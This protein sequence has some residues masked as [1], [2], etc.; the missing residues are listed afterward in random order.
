ML[1]EGIARKYQLRGR[2]STIDLL[3]KA[4]CSVN[5][6]NNIFNIKSSFK[7]VC[8]RWSTVLSLPVQ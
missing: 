2:L 6:V 7:L 8:T 5:K 1:T 3:I 4:P